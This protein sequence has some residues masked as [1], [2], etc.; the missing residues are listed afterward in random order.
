M[1]ARH[2]GLWKRVGALRTEVLVE[3][4]LDVTLCTSQDVCYS[5]VVQHFHRDRMVESSMVVSREV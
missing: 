1:R 4:G 5:G 3:G 2:D